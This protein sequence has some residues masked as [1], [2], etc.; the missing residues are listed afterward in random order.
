MQS[1]GLFNRGLL[2]S[3]TPEQ[4]DDNSNP[5]LIVKNNGGKKITI[6]L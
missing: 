1:L 3:L 6:W 5:C 4:A 2:G